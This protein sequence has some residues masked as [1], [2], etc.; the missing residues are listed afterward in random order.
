MLKS[1]NDAANHLGVGRTNLYN[2]IKEGR[3]VTVKI[4]RRTL[5]K[6]SSIETLIRENEVVR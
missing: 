1:I 4:G 5:V 2:L 3:L 6:M